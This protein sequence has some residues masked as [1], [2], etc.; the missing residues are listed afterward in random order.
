[1]VTPCLLGTTTKPPKGGKGGNY[2][3]LGWLNYS[4]LAI[5]LGMRHG[6]FIVQVLSQGKPMKITVECA[7]KVL[8][9]IC[10]RKIIFTSHAK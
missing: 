3:T 1:M 9:E 8:L 6:T 10:M 5:Q 2:K 7:P 4:N